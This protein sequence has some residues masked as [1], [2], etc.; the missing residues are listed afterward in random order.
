[1]KDYVLQYLSYL[2]M[3][4]DTSAPFMSNQVEWEE[5]GVG[6]GGLL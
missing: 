6:G 1:M 4:P 2:I 5:G 3:K